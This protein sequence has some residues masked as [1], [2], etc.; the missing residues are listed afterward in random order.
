VGRRADINREALMGATRGVRVWLGIGALGLAAA[1]PVEA[2]Q[3]LKVYISADMEGI[4]GAVTQ[5]QLGPA[6][7]EYQRF[8]EIM[9]A[10][11]LAAI[12]GARA[13]GA[14]EILVSD[15]HG[16]GQN[17]LIER[18]PE[19]VRVIRSWP[20]PLG[21]MEGIDPTFHAAIF[22]GYHAGATNPGGVRA[23]TFSSANYAA[24]RLNGRPVAESEFNAAV[25]GHFGV[26]VVLI[27][28]D[29]A[30]V[31]E[32]QEMV[33]G[34]EGA[35]V[36]RAIGFH[37]AETMTPAAAQGLIRRQAEV[38]VRNRAQVAPVRLATPVALELTFKNYR[39]VEVLAFLPQ[40]ERAD[41]RTIRFVGRDMVEIATFM[42]FVGNYQAGLSP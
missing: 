35:V 1:A 26:P 21:M 16:N 3:P 15:S 17:L 31:S 18:L 11:V 24:V 13:A 10:E 39:P 32:L 30:A 8:R 41:A 12:E 19:D 9:T 33:R 36:K 2:Q 14:T 38:G 42:A 7:F 22:V 37:S 27:T 6:G 25:A 23:H 20:R 29:D 5:E 28:G 4:A 40:V 34:V